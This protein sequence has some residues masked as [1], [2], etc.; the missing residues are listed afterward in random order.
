VDVD[1]STGFSDEDR[2]LPELSVATD[3]GLVVESSDSDRVSAEK[4]LTDNIFDEYKPQV[5]IPDS[6]PH[7][8]KLVQSAAMASVK[9]PKATYSP[10]LPAR[11]IE[12]GG[13]SAAQLE[14][15]V[16]AGQKT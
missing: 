16:Y 10:R 7:P 1:R 9:S 13:L 15:V 2:R 3:K 14:P 5:K 11:L 4:E 12:T 6:K 8:G